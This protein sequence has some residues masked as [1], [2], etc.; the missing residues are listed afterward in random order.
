M[1]R[2]TVTLI[3]VGWGDSILIESEDSQ[4]KLH[5]ALV[6]SNDNSEMRSSYIFLRRHFEKLGLKIKKENMPFFRFV[7]LSHAHT[8]HGRGLESIMREFRTEN[9]IYPKFHE[10]GILSKLQDFSRR[11]PKYVNHFQS[12]DTMDAIDLGDVVIT[13]LWPKH[14][15]PP[16]KDTENNNSVVMRLKLGEI[17][18]I[19]TG[20]AEKEVWE[21]IA[22]EIPDDTRFLKVPHHGSVNGT[23]D[24]QNPAWLYDCP[25]SAK[26]GIS[27]HVTPFPHP[28]QRVINLFN[29]HRME[30]F[31]TD[32][33]YHLSFETDG[34]TVSVK[35]S[36]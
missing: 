13:F 24:G 14:N 20:D 28:H 27:S 16:M 25:R 6:D 36:H 1:S 11:Y 4:G 26:L 23:F 30:F 17:S 10:P 8:D 5:F 19:L 29:F 18:F 15:D 34:Q 9:F 22:Q 33:N 31:R 12:V 21:R 32:I 35:Y 2:L 7:L 3:D